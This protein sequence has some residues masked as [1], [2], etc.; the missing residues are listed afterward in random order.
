[1]TYG[2][3]SV[4]RQPVGPWA[5]FMCQVQPR[6]RTPDYSNYRNKIQKTCC[7]N[8]TCAQHTRTQTPQCHTPH[9][10]APPGSAGPGAGLSEA[11][12]SLSIEDSRSQPLCRELAFCVPII[13]GRGHRRRRTSLFLSEILRRMHNGL[14]S[15][16]LVTERASATK[17]V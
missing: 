14:C 12:V 11:A 7:L 13:L 17:A 4:Y 8:S 15:P 1:M 16:N 5:S 6:L 10:S 2:A 3:S 9:S